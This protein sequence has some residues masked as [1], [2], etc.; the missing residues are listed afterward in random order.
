MASVVGLAPLVLLQ[1]LLLILP[2]T[3][4][5]RN[6]RDFGAAF[7]VESLACI[8]MGVVLIVS[9]RHAALGAK[10]AGRMLDELMDQVRCRH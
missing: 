2:D 8:A 7:T 4:E 3:W 1:P 10:S 6:A 9:A 5:A